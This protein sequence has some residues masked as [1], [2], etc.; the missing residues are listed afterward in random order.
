MICTLEMLL[1]LHFEHRA[2]RSIASTSTSPSYTSMRSC[3]DIWPTC[4]HRQ[5]RTRW[6]W[7]IDDSFIMFYFCSHCLKSARQKCIVGLPLNDAAFHAP[8]VNSVGAFLIVTPLDISS[9]NW[10][11]ICNLNDT[12]RSLLHLSSARP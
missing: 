11:W 8:A 1:P 4:P 9:Q 7:W 10:H 6:L 3:T 12:R 5:F 2:A